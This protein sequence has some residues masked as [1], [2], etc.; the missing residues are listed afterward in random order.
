[1]RCLPRQYHDSMI[2]ACHQ[3][4]TTSD[5]QEAS[6]VAVLYGTLRNEEKIVAKEPTAVVAYS[7]IYSLMSYSRSDTLDIEGLHILTR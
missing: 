4:R 5:E 6:G 1:M 7:S 3:S 2:E